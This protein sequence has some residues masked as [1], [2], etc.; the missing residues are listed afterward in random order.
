MRM[1]KIFHNGLEIKYNPESDSIKEIRYGGKKINH[2]KANGKRYHYNSAY[3][4]YN[5]QEQYD[6]LNIHQLNS[7]EIIK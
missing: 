6:Q 5:S 4:V 3:K 1:K 7:I 2:V